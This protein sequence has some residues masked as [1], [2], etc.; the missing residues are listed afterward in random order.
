[1][2]SVLDGGALLLLLGFAVLGALLALGRGLLNK[3]PAGD[4]GKHAL[5]A[6]L[7]AFAGRRTALAE[8]LAASNDRATS[9]SNIIPMWV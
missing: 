5:E 3:E 4:I 9:Q 6:A 1:M 7:A 8:R 2:A